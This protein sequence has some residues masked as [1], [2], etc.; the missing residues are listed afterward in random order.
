MR[1]EE[2][3]RDSAR[4]FGDKV[5]LIAGGLRVSY[6]DLDRASDHLAGALAAR[7][8]ARG[9]RVIVFMDNCREAVIAIF[10]ALKV[11]AVF[12]PINPSTKAEK[13]AYVINNCGARGLITQDK[14]RA[15]ASAALA[16]SPSVTLA[17]VAGGRAPI[18]CDEMSFEAAIAADDEPPARP[19]IDIDL[20]M[21]VYTSGST[22]FP[23]GVMMTHQNVVAAATSITT[24]LENTADDVILNVLP[25]SF[26]YGLYQVLMAAKVGATL[27]L[28][29][30]FAFPQ[31]IFAKMAAERVT[32]LPLVPTMAALILQMR[33][34][35]PGAFPHLRYVTNTAAAL[36]PAHIARLQ[37][38][39][40]AAR[41]YSMYGVTEC[42]RCTYLPPAELAR[43]PGSVGIAIPGTE[44]YVVDEHGARAAPGVVGE[45]VI[46]GAHV[47]KGY[48]ENPEATARALRPGPHPWEKVLYTGDLF[49]ADEDGFLYFV[50]RKDDIIKTRGEKVSPK[51]VENALYAL[52][53]V[54]EAAVVGVPDPVL[55]LALKAV[56]AA[57]AQAK[58]TA[59]AVIRHCARHLEDFMVPKMVEFRDT[60]PKTES[61][62]ISRRLIAADALE[63]AA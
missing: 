56:I 43:R 47:M 48:W 41:L 23:K 40:P 57:D 31:A 13:L 46:R 38:L 22:G 5:A 18:L 19:G 29:Q 6:R 33:D 14:L 36:P 8:I 12:S 58:L 39:F 45:L 44:A 20:A 42:K 4:R 51:E 61:G 49:R 7:G 32:G 15:V 21:L 54:R 2:F 9:D 24:Y 3:L 52:P 53:G 50:A 63:P 25:I 59:H 37:A 30:S 17:V 55:G 11:G 1:V 28:E 27:V 26:D 16:E 60:L 34:L 62:K 10:A 35:E